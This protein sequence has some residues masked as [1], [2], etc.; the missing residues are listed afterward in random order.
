M[1]SKVEMVRRRGNVVLFWLLGSYAVVVAMGLA[2]VAR[3]W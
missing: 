2:V 1:L 3:G